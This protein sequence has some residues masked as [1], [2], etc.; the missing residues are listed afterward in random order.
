[1]NPEAA[2]SSG[3]TAPSQTAGTT[4]RA[5]R[6][7]AGGCHPVTGEKSLE[8]LRAEE[9]GSGIHA[10]GRGLGCSLENGLSWDGRG[11]SENSQ[12]TDAGTPGRGSRRPV[13]SAGSASTLKQ[14][15]I[16]LMQWASG[17]S[18]KGLGDTKP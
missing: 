14:G 7:Q 2:L 10:L 15:Q 9:E 13:T 12:N 3:D 5:D 1:M 6:P 8:T 16:R 18:K 17:W 4:P 11:G